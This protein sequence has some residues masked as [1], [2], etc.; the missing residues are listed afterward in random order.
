[1]KTTDLNGR[2]RLGSKEPSRQLDRRLAGFPFI[3][4]MMA[5]WIVPAALGQGAYQ[6]ERLKSFGDPDQGR[7]PTAGMY[8]C[9]RSSADQPF[10]SPVL[11]RPILGIGPGGTG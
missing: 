2:S 7:G 11:I 8:V 5:C 1:M 3:A 4:V 9:R 10:G 6:Y